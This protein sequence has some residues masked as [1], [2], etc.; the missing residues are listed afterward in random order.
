MGHMDPFFWGVHGHL[1]PLCFACGGNLHHSQLIRKDSP[2]PPLI[3]GV[4]YVICW[5]IAQQ[6]WL[7]LI[8]KALLHH[9]A[10]LLTSMMVNVRGQSSLND[11]YTGP[12]CESRVM[13][14]VMFSI[15]SDFH[16]MIQLQRCHVEASAALFWEME[17]WVHLVLR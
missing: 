9:D 1:D 2:L 15:S 4:M 5:K 13:S 8:C 10:K 11:P 3:T 12:S 7:A 17:L 16:A 14:R 6:L